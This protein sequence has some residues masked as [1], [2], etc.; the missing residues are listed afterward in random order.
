MPELKY[1]LTVNMREAFKGFEKLPQADQEAIFG[2]IVTGLANWQA[3]YGTEPTID[4]V[5]V[6]C[7]TESKKSIDTLLAAFS[8]DPERTPK[9]VIAW[10]INSRSRAGLKHTVLYDLNTQEFSCS[11]E[12]FQFRGMPCGHISVV[13]SIPPPSGV[14][15][16]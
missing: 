4:D 11:C 1:L 14:E 5:T 2:S 9:Y 10:K 7:L 16:L 12:Q 15:I 6:N 8:P 3:A 13:R